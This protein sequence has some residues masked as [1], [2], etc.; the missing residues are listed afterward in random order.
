VRFDIRAPGAEER[1]D[2]HPP[3]G[4]DTGQ[5][6]GPRP[7]EEAHENRLGLV[8]GGMSG[9]DEPGADAAGHLSEGPI[10]R[11][12]RLGFEPVPGRLASH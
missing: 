9:G 4:G 7:F 2:E 11:A 3:R 10:A 12:A 6:A 8:V 5:A 1:P